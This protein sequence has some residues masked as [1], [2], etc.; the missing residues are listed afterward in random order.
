[1][2]VVRSLYVAAAA[3]LV[4]GLG[5]RLAPT[6]LPQAAAAP[7]AVPAEAQPDTA[8]TSTPPVPTYDAIV[9]ANIFSQDR[10]PPAVRFSLPGREAAPTKPRGPTLRLYGITAGAQGAVALIDA[11][12]N[13]PGA[14]IY[15]LGDLVAGARVIAITDSTVTLA[16][17]SGPLVLR[18]QPA[19]RRRGP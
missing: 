19:E 8:P 15:R 12:P 7:P 13:I 18:M 4:A 6:P 17:P 14:E 5:L 3:L 2:I 16:E 9:A 10:T 11:D 1:V